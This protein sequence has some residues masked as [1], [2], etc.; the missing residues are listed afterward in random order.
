MQFKFPRWALLVSCIATACAAQAGTLSLQDAAE[1]A[2][3]IETRYSNGQGAAATAFTTE[4]FANGEIM[5]GWDDRSLTTTLPSCSVL[6]VISRVELPRS[7]MLAPLPSTSACTWPL[8]SVTWESV[9]VIVS[10]RPPSTLRREP[11][12]RF[13][14]STVLPSRTVADWPSRSRAS[15]DVAGRAARA[16]SRHWVRGRM[17]RHWG[18][19]E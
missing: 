15:T 4:Y 11:L 12:M 16:N 10:V 18:R 19:A 17:R 1:N 7:T 9:L 8:F 14:A 2:A 6:L 5:M 13:Q 3:R